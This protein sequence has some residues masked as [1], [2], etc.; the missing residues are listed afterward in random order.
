MK[1]VNK[2]LIKTRVFVFL[3][4]FQRFFGGFWGRL[5]CLLLA[6]ETDC[7]PEKQAGFGRTQRPLAKTTSAN[8]V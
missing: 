1:E 6:M 3:R 4:R 5:I 8:P 7:L 2:N